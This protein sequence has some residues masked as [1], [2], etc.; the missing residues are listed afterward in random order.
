MKV[1]CYKDFGPYKKG[2]T[3]SLSSVDD[4]KGDD[5][6]DH[7]VVVYEPP[8]FEYSKVTVEDIYDFLKDLYRVKNHDYGDSFNKGCD[9]YGIVSAVS[10]MDE[11]MER[12]N[13]LY[14]NPSEAKV[15]ESL[16][17]TLLDLANY[18]VMTAVYLKNKEQ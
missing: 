4:I 16:V 2:E 17:D 10:R 9:K 7:F 1:E 8:K 5:L 14:S 3:Y 11:K 15:K 13:T 6:I 12:I 18:A